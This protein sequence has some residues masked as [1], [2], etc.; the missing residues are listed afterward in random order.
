M[1]APYYQ[2]D[3]ALVHHRGF[4]FHADD[5]APGVLRLLEPVRERGGLVV[6]LGCGSGLLTRHLLDA[7]HRVVAT[8][9]SPAMLELARDVAADAVEIRELVLPDDPIP[10]AD[11]IVG[12]GHALNYLPDEPAI[13]RALAAVAR[14]LRPGGVLAIDLCDLEWGDARRGAPN[15]GRVE[16]DWAIV[17]EFSVPSPDRFVRQMATFVRN[18]DGSWRRD[19]ERHDNVLIDTR[20]VPTLLA[21]HG[22]RA[23]IASSF[24]TERLPVGL[25]AVIGNRIA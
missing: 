20:R 19:D 23:T 7:G 22:V 4:G 25:R 1:E 10:P 16:D 18:D 3:L 6:E 17:T 12:V 14:A 2:R 9:A 11:A 21:E 24:G 15:L 5:C 13:D 8:D